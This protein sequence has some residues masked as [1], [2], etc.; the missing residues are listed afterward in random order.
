MST[1]WEGRASTVSHGHV[2]AWVRSLEA[3]SGVMTRVAGYLRDAVDLAV[4]VAQAVVDLFKEITYVVTAGI[5]FANIPIYGEL[6]AV[7]ALRDVWRLLNDA[8]KVLRVFWEA[9]VVLKDC[10]RAAV[11]GLTAE[12]LPQVPKLP[13]SASAA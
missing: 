5:G 7:R 2:L 9:L 10:L 3:Q 4:A 12:S 1:A 6:R 13:A 8:R 11:T